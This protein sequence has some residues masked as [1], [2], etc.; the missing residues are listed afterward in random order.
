MPGPGAC[1]STDEPPELLRVWPGVVAVAV[2]GGT[3][4]QWT[5]IADTNH[6]RIYRQG[7]WFD[8][9]FD[10]EARFVAETEADATTPEALFCGRGVR[11]SAVSPR[12]CAEWNSTMGMAVC[13][14]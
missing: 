9:V 10:M 6:W 3:G 11:C 12:R 4:A 14:S 13:S 5:F 1:A 2:F 7:M 8:P